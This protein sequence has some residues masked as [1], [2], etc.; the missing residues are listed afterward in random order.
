MLEGVAEYRHVGCNPR[1]P[2]LYLGTFSNMG[3]FFCENFHIFD[4][5]QYM[6]VVILGIV[7]AE[8]ATPL[9]I[10]NE[11]YFLPGEVRIDALTQSGRIFHCPD[12]GYANFYSFTLSLNE[13][14][15]VVWVYLHPYP[16]AVQLKGLYGFKKELVIDAE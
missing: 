6:K 7:V 10:G 3:L 2:R 13:E 16:N 12:N 8:S 14:K 5:L 15:D 9:I 4:I 11:Y 1:H